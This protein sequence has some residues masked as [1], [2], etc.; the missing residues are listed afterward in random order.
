MVFVLPLILGK[1]NEVRFK[2]PGSVEAVVQVPGR[3]Y[4]WNDYQTMFE[5]KSYQRS[6]SLPDGTQIQIRNPQGG[7]LPF[8]GDTSISSSRG[9]SAENSVGYVEIVSPGKVKI[10]ITGGNEERIF[11]FSQSRILKIF[12]LV[13]AGLILSMI[14]GLLGIGIIVWGIIKT[15]RS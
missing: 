3:Y 2:A 1:S 6:K 4:I 13:A 5:G 7:L 14:V 15:A 12:G 10:E 8:V 9:S 11:S